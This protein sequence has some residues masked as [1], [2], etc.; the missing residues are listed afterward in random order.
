MESITTSYLSEGTSANTQRLLHFSQK[1]W[2][3][4][5]FQD[6]FLYRALRIEDP[7]ILHPSSWQGEEGNTG[8]FKDGFLLISS[9]QS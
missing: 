6:C 1:P 4:G 8:M 3:T 2:R 9:E 5:H 7:A